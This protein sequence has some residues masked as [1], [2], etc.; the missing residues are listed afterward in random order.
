MTDYLLTPERRNQITNLLNH[1]QD[2][3]HLAQQAIDIACQEQLAECNIPARQREAVELVF[4]RIGG[5][6][7]AYTAEC[8]TNFNF[9]NEQF[10]SLKQEILDKIGGSDERT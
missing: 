10:Q 7:I 6:Q 1:D 5:Y 2:S 9:T 3:F 4:E 8:G